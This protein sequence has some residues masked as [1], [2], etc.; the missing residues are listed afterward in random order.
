MASPL[1]SEFSDNNPEGLPLSMVVIGV[2]DLGVPLQF[3][4]CLKCKEPKVF[5]IEY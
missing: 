2:G 3:S 1:G 5:T 4:P